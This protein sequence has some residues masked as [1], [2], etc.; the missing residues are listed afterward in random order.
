M[1]FYY[2]QGGAWGEGE[3]VGIRGGITRQNLTAV[4]QTTLAIVFSLCLKKAR[5]WEAKLASAGLRLW[6]GLEHSIFALF[7]FLVF[8]GPHL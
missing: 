1:G 5:T 6:A 8:L 3:G 2:K 7:F 4:L